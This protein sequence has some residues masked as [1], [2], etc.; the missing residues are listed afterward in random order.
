MTNYKSK[1]MH[2]IPSNEVKI[3]STSSNAF[4]YSQR[5]MF[6]EVHMIRNE[7]LFPVE[8]RICFDHSLPFFH[9]SKYKI[10]KENVYAHEPQDR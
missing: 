6:S 8:E 5:N 2:I 3:L 9:R 1:Y 7:S 4:I 10:H